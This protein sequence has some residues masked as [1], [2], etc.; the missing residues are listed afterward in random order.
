MYITQPCERILHH[1]KDEC[2]LSAV[3]RVC[4]NI[5]AM[6]NSLGRW[7]LV[8]IFSFVPKPT[9]SHVILI[10]RWMYNLRSPSPCVYAL[11]DIEY[12]T[13]A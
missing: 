4:A 7:L 1:I 5:E 10:C 11:S 9:G 6:P 12:A 3:I 13:A 2:R 8:L